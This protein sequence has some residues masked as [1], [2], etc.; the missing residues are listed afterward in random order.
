MRQS[1]LFFLGCFGC[2]SSLHA[3]WDQQLE[4]G[5]YYTNDAL[6][7]NNAQT[8]EASNASN[9]RSA[10]L[11]G[12]QS[13]YQ[14]WTADGGLITSLAANR[15]QGVSDSHDRQSIQ[16]SLDKVQS[17][18]PLWLFNGSLQLQHY[19]DQL[20]L[21]NGY[22]SAGLLLIASYQDQYQRGVDLG[23]HFQHENH[24]RD[25]SANY[26]ADRTTWSLDYALAHKINAPFWHVHIS[27]HTTKS[28]DS[29]R[30]FTKTELALG[31]KQWRW[32]RMTL[33][34]ALG[35]QHY[36]YAGSSLFGLMSQLGG[37]GGTGGGMMSMNGQPSFNNGLRMGLFRPRKDNYLNLDVSALY[38]LSS[39]LDW[40][41]S[42]QL[43]DYRSTQQQD[44]SL[45]NL[46]T[47]LVYRF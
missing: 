33:N 27:Y 22:D 24:D 44:R 46:H 14:H 15:E 31:Y 18:S 10:L 20:T 36:D 3:Q 38:S 16:L 17:L 42:F 47:R 8:G 26:T 21:S 19:Q 5:L 34:M 12:L 39:Q 43:S 1:I 45:F 35:Y 7:D 11:L 23:L 25:A 29:R 2:V 32:Q 28:N 4:T 13:R 41:I 30:N 6:L 40:L 37:S 9:S